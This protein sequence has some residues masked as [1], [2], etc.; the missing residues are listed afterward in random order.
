M[1]DDYEEEEET[2]EVRNCRY[3]VARKARRNIL[4]GDLVC[5]TT[6]FD[7]IEGGPRLGYVRHER[8]V[9]WG[10]GHTTLVG[11]GNWEKRGEFAAVHPTFASQAEAAN[12]LYKDSYK[13]R[14]GN[15]DL[16]EWEARVDEYEAEYGVEWERA[17]W[18][19]TAVTR[20]AVREDNLKAVA[21]REA[22]E[23]QQAEHSAIVCARDGETVGYQ[24]QTYTVGRCYTKL[25]V[26]SNL[27]YAGGA[28]DAEARGY[29]N[30][31]NTETGNVLNYRCSR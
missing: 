26:F 31:T 12:A 15:S 8:I 18:A 29:R 6:G 10:P 1:Y 3:V 28:G 2:I 9:G 20:E 13:V 11:S 22:R 30:L 16:A 19:N 21:K 17:P 27:E 23:A 25:V 14:W 7:Y 4:P 5:V 24:G